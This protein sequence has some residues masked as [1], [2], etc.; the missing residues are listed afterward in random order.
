MERWTNTGRVVYDRI[1]ER[2]GAPPVFFHWHRSARAAAAG[3]LVFG[4]SVLGHAQPSRNGKKPP[5]PALR[6]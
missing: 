6:R 2:K 3:A 5:E 4:L 1:H